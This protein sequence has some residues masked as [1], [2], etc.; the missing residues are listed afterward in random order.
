MTEHQIQNTVALLQRFPASLDALLRGLPEMWIF[1]NEGENTWSVFDVVAHLV[2]AEAT[3]WIPRIRTALQFGE[4]QEFQSFNRLA[5]REESKGKPLGH[6][7]DEFAQL[8]SDTLVE[9]RELNLQPE[10][11]KKRGRHPALGAVSVSELLATWAVHD[12]THLHQI[13]RILAYQYRAT[14]GPLNAYL[15]VLQCEGHSA[16]R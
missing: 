7:L 10:D 14:V 11:L 3:N 5:F 8:R 2:N 13:S 9:L 16:P 12:L 15:G 1:Q 4:T 6:L